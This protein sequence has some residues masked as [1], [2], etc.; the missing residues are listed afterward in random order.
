MFWMISEAATQLTYLL[1]AE[2]V[3]ESDVPQFLTK[4]AVW[5]TLRSK[6][7]KG[8]LV[9]YSRGA[10]RLV[11]KNVW[12]YP[13]MMRRGLMPTVEEQAVVLREVEQIR[14]LTEV[15]QDPSQPPRIDQARKPIA[16]NPSQGETLVEEIDELFVLD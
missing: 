16:K 7:L 10:L 12:D 2:R 5:P 8:R 4:E 14:S 3:V 13:E 1:A 6:S 9:G 11:I 15:C